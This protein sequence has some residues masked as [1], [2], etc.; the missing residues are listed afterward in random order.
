MLS[1][2]KQMWLGLTQRSRRG[3]LAAGLT[4]LLALAIW[5]A[6]QLK[7]PTFA[8]LF[9]NLQPTD[10]EAIVSQLQTSKVP[11]QLSDNGQTIS[12]P[13]AQVYQERLALAGKGLPNQGVVGFSLLNN[14]SLTETN[15]DRQVNFMR[16]LEGELTRTILYIN[17]VQ[18][19]RVHLVMPQQSTFLDANT[20]PPTAGV[21]LKLVPGTQLSAAQVRGIMH[22]VAAS[23]QG[24]QPKDVTVLDSHGNLLSAAVQASAADPTGSMAQQQIDVT[25]AFDQQL[26]DKLQTLLGQVLGPDNVVTRVQATL[27][28]DKQSTTS[29]LFQPVNGTQQG[30]LKSINQLKEQ[31]SGTGTPP[32][33]VGTTSNTPSYPF[34]S[35]SGSKSNYTQDQTQSN[36]AISQTTQQT[37]VAPGKVARLSVAVAV[38]R[39]LTSVQQKSIQ[40]MVMAAIGADPARQDQITVIGMPFATSAAQNLVTKPAATA[41]PAQ[42][43]L[44]LALAGLAAAAVAA[45][46]IFSVRSGRRDI[47]AEAEERRLAERLVGERAGLDG[48]LALPEFD[49]DDPDGVRRAARSEQE[50]RRREIVSV[51]QRRPEDVANVLRSWITEEER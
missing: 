6:F 31:F 28:F 5:G 12:V 22:L 2:S 19:A 34:T 20:P 24:L 3:V 47:L 14:P 1:K 30:V 39:T 17:D 23:V 35:G 15:F 13:V 36:Y 27:N 25:N 11:Y 32:K 10:A 44:P 42:S 41:K 26:Q 46:L 29:E 18:A 48:D 8:P 40:Q 9:T 38:N 4:A 50:A 51:V 7:G 37:T 16:A 45:A 49:P 43:P 33:P 21:L